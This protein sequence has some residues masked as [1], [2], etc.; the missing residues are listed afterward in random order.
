[1]TKRCFFLGLLLAFLFMLFANPSSVSGAR[2][3]IQLTNSNLD[4]FTPHWTQDGQWIVYN[5][6]YD[7]FHMSDL[8]GIFRTS[9]ENGG[10]E[11]PVAT[12]IYSGPEIL[13]YFDLSGSYGSG[14]V[15]HDWCIDNEAPCPSDT[16]VSDWRIKRTPLLGGGG[17]L[18]TDCHAILPRISPDGSL[19]FYWFLYYNYSDLNTHLSL[20]KIPIA[21]GTPITLMDAPWFE[22]SDARWSPDGNWIAFT[23]PGSGVYKVSSSGGNMIQISGG[24]YDLDPPEWSPD[25]NWILCSADSTVIKISTIGGGQQVLANLG[26][27]PQWTPSGK[28][29]VYINPVDSYLYMIDANAT[30]EPRKLAKSVINIEGGEN[31]FSPNFA[32]SPN[33]NWLAYVKHDATGHNQIYKLP[34][35]FMPDP[36]GWQFAN[37]DTNMWPPDWWSQFDYSDP[38][39]PQDWRNW[40][41]PSDFPDWELFAEAFGAHQCYHQTS[42]RRIYNEAAVDIWIWIIKRFYGGE[43]FKGCCSGFAISSLLYF[44]SYLCLSNTFP[45]ESSVYG[46]PLSDSSRKLVN[47]YSIYQFGHTHLAHYLYNRKN[48]ARQALDFL[49]QMFATEYTTTKTLCLVSQNPKHPGAHEVVAC[50]LEQVSGQ[51]GKYR[52]AIYDS[53]LPGQDTAIYIDSISGTWEYACKPSWGGAEGIFLMDPIY[54]YISYP[55]LPV[56]LQPL[57]EEPIVEGLGQENFIEIFASNHCDIVIN[58]SNGELI[59]YLNTDSILIDSMANALPIIPITGYTHPPIG[60]FLPENTYTVHISNNVDTTFYSSLFDDSTIFT[61]Y[62]YDFQLGQTDYLKCS[63][64]GSGFQVKTYD[65]ELKN[66]NL[67]STNVQPDQEIVCYMKGLVLSQNDSLLFE[68][69]QQEEFKV[70]NTGSSKTYDLTLELASAALNP[71]FEH[72]SI[73]ICAFSAHQVSPSWEG[74]DTLTV[75]IFIDDNLDGIFDDTLLIENQYVHRGDVNGDRQV[76]I[77]DVVYL[78]NYLFKNGPEPIPVES[79]DVNCDDNVDIVDVVYLINYLFK[80]GP[81]PC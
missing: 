42:P 27:L 50:K 26:R 8:T 66:V 38:K 36:D 31:W 11:F 19:I 58:N 72:H 67:K 10:T 32:C 34:L 43:E 74:L 64:N 35:Y 63:N 3:E 2:P 14:V 25:G 16:N 77:V 57:T 73:P 37:T 75:P 59:G 6:V 48:P 23:I 44:N 41:N 70:T 47:K 54:T 55:F 39:Y 56:I 71:I 49:K 80:N 78:I 9:A 5:C 28:H 13:I 45:G 40:A 76:T 61:Y 65:V 24:N 18:L 17:T 79:G 20:K 7:T 46:V 30:C 21:G 4:H 29:I 60:Y 68:C 51:P 69:V 22:F 15:V 53:N 33:G 1:M 62:R 12:N 81:P 52:V